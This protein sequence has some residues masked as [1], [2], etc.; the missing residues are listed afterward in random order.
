MATR[1]LGRNI[2]VLS[3]V[4]FFQDAATEMLFPVVPIFITTVLGAPV[5][6]VG[7][8]E[9]LAEGVSSL[10]KAVSGGLADRFARRP[11]VAAGYGTSAA[12][13]ALIALATTWPFVLF[14]R[15]LDR[16]GKGI[17]T[18]PRDALIDVDTVTSDR[19]RAFGFHRM[20]D[21][22]GA[23]VGPLA[24]L[25][26][27]EALHHELRPLFAVAVIP[28]FVSVLFI[29]FVREA[30]RPPA[31]AA[32]AAR[33]RFSRTY[34]NVLVLL[35]LF[36]L[37]NFSVA[38]V[39]VRL[40]ELGFSTV[41]IF[42]AYALLNACYSLFSYPAGRLSDAVPRRFVFAAGM[43]TFAASFLGFALVADARWAWGLF[44]LFGV[45]LALT[46]GVGT[47][48]IGDLAPEGS[49]GSA[50]GLYYS[51]TGFAVLAAGLWA[52][53]LWGA[54]G[55]MPFLVSA[56]CAAAIA[57]AVTFWRGASEARG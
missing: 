50:L 45:F 5:A 22:F 40:K 44:A 41:E 51:I 27:Y 18:S 29:A 21:N 2:I 3:W 24:G 37:V 25:G 47:A 11:L 39:I 19:G 42:L 33:P 23:V 6:V 20:M 9:G 28:A 43:A 38:L 36:N 16:I 26:L 35:T 31:R 48:W 49:V 52:G 15:V 10:M 13:K 17:R 46:D 8:V 4:S 55:R 1:P 54:G 7:I 53:A 12:S 34:W 57:A 56:C 32:V 14:C 30:P